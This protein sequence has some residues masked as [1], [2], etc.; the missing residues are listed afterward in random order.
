M[1]GFFLNF[2]G[3]DGVGKS[4]QIDLFAE[5]LRA[6]G[7]DFVQTREPGGTE[8]AEEI[9]LVVKKKRAETVYPMTQVLL[10]FAAR[11]QNH[12]NFVL[13]NIE[14]GK[15]VITDRHTSSTIAYQLAAGVARLDIDVIDEIVMQNIRPDLTIILDISEEE[16]ERRILSRIKEDGEINDIFDDA[17]REYKRNVRNGYLLQARAEPSKFRVIDA[18]DTPEVIHDK[19]KECVNAFMKERGIINGGNQ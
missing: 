7:V 19:I 6:Q 1:T 14:A 11:H 10:F 9:R 15:V 5:Y 2:E 4:M 18:G 17:S 13:P 12:H 16:S 8:M 3:A